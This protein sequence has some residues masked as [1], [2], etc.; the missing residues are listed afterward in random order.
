MAA[1]IAARM[2]SIC[3][4]RARWCYQLDWLA[5]FVSVEW[6][7]PAPWKTIHTRRSPPFFSHCLSYN[8]KIEQAWT[9][10]QFGEISSFPLYSLANTI[11]LMSRLFDQ[12]LGEGKERVRAWLARP[13]TYILEKA[14][15]TMRI[16]RQYWRVSLP[17]NSNETCAPV[18][19]FI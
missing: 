3:R 9:G 17:F 7:L 16:K 4:R 15:I 12:G 19:L 18:S 6:K 10:G 8:N 2:S 13:L 11:F 14:D 5:S 1:G